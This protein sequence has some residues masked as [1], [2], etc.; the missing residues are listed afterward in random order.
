M[1]EEVRGYLAVQPPT[2]LFRHSRPP[3]PSHTR[4]TLRHTRACRG[5]LAVTC[6]NIRVERSEIAAAERGNDGGVR[7][8]LAVT[9]TNHPC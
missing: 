5:Y 1:T 2:P 9:C 3:I 6:T 4:H 7:G 8:Y